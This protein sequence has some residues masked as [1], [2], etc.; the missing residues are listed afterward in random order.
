M[1]YSHSHAVSL[2][3]FILHIGG[4]LTEPLSKLGCEIT[5]IDVIEDLIH[6]ARRHADDTNVESNL[7]YEVVSLKEHSLA[8]SGKYD[9]VIAS[10]VI[11]HVSDKGEFIAECVN[12]LKPNG[13]VFITTINKSILSGVFAIMIP[14][15]LVRVMAKGTHEYDL[16]VE[17]NVVKR[18]LQ[19][20][21]F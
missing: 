17:P 8:M 13:S 9:V 16:L 3:Y 15:Y 21:E 19:E 20:S 5:G 11:E 12:C 7:N 2:C 6:V 1:R 4:I 10:E 14:E 18:L